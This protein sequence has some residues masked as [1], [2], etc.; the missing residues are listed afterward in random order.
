MGHVLGPDVGEF[1]V[2]AF[3]VVEAAGMEC[4][5]AFVGQAFAGAG[6]GGGAHLGAL[7]GGFGALFDGPA[8]FAE[9]AFVVA[10]ESV[11]VDVELVVGQV[12][13]E[14]EVAAL[15]AGDGLL[16]VVVVHG[17]L[18]GW[19][20]GG[21]GHVG[22]QGGFQDVEMGPGVDQVVGDE[23][24]DA[25]GEFFAAPGDGPGVQVQGE[26]TGVVVEGLGGGM[27]GAE[28]VAD[29]VGSGGHWVLRECDKMTG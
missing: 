6:D 10:V 14:A 2:D 17:L 13:H 27:G 4:D 25:L 26:G 18:S 8:F 16:F 5:V 23:F 21:R 15:C 1:D 19:L 12:G 3:V 28:G 9:D 29:G 20:S 22:A 7:G 11:F 24:L